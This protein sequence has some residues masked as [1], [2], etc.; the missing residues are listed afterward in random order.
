[1]GCGGMIGIIVR[2]GGWGSVWSGVQR[3]NSFFFY[4]FTF[5]LSIHLL[6]LFWTCLRSC[7]DFISFPFSTCFISGV[8]FPFP[9][10]F[11]LGGLDFACYLEVG[12]LRLLQ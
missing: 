9:Y 10:Q 5:I 2:L 11:E 3:S 1:M 4:L 7:C 6:F 8:F 12:R